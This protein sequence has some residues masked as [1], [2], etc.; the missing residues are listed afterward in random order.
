MPGTWQEKMAEIVEEARKRDDFVVVHHYDADGCSSGAIMNKALLREGKKVSRKW[1]KQLYRETIAEIRGLG[2]N[3]VFVDFGSGQLGYLKEEFGENLF[4]FDHHQR[5]DVGHPHHF[6]PFEF[7]INGGTEVSASGIAYLFA[8]TLNQK[9]LDLLP[10]AIV[11]A[12]GDV[13]DFSGK[14]I[15]LNAEIVKE[16]AAAGLVKVE[17]DL[18]LYGRVTR[19]LVQFLMYSTSPMLPELTAN[20]E[21]CRKFLQENGIRLKEASSSARNGCGT[22]GHSGDYGGEFSGQAGAE[23][24]GDA[25]AERWRTYIDLSR[26]EKSLLA[27]ALILHLHKFRVPEWKISELFGEVYS[28]PEEDAHS[29]CSEAKEYSTLLNACGRHSFADVG[30]EVCLGNRGEFYSRAI[31][32]MAEH[33]RQ[34]REGIEFVLKNGLKE[35]EAFYYFDAGGKIGESIVGIVAGMLYGSNLIVTN[36][37]IIAIAQNEDGS[38]KIS[39]RATKDLVHAGINLGIAF[40]DVCAEIGGG[41]EGGGHA[42]AAGLKLE[43]RNLQA[44][45]EKLNV[46]LE[47]QQGKTK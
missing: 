24:N 29:P 6:T 42:V 3:Y 45:L 9:N 27:T 41:S 39:G 7:G 20:E 19:P 44:F 5:T 21:N 23:V 16:G 46:K 25:H 40:R 30:V 22:I 31:T 4:V 38:L 2:R 47:E 37:P 13:Q 15:G 11:G 35:E 8:R 17:K 12:V 18:R 33:R 43:K 28:F 14:L 1:V 10:L 26:D 32:L 36:K 34:L